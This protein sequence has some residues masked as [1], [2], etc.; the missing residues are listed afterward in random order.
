MYKLILV[1]ILLFFSA[2]ANALESLK[3]LSQL[4]EHHIIFLVFEKNGCPWCVRYKSELD[5]IIKQKYKTDIKFFKVQKGSEISSQLR[6]EFGHKIIIYPMTYILKL[7]SNKESE[8]VHEIYG[9]QTVEYIE[10]I[11]QNELFIK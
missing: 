7:N 9:Y 4:K 8:I 1:T 3:S 10:D 5:Y 2:S 11:F 6:K